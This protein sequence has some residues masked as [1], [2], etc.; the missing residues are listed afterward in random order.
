MPKAQVSRSPFKKKTQNIQPSR[1]KSSRF[2]S[3]CCL[4]WLGWHVLD[5]STCQLVSGVESEVYLWPALEQHCQLQPALDL[6]CLVEIWGRHVPPWLT[7]KTA[8]HFSWGTSSQA[9]RLFPDAKK[10]P[11]ISLFAYTH[12]SRGKPWHITCITLDAEASF[13]VYI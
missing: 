2:H 7:G 5:S 8:H 13:L 1:E 12:W 4:Y 11:W 3:Q 9:P 10:W 6:H